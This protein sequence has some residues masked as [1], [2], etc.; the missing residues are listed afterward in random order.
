M[1]ATD[2]AGQ[3]SIVTIQ[4]GEGR[5]LVVQPSP[6]RYVVGQET[7]IAPLTTD[8]CAALIENVVAWLQAAGG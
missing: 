8:A 4:A 5:V 7:A 1:L 6:D 2:N 3:P